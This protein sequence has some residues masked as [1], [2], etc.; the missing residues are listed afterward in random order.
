MHIKWQLYKGGEKNSLEADVAKFTLIRIQHFK[1][2]YS[3]K[4]MT[5]KQ[6]SNDSGSFN[7]H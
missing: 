6:R 1:E 5:N 3:F 7:E 4:Y 2:F